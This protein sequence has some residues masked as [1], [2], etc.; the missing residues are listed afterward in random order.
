MGS[1]VGY[2][3]RDANTGFI[4]AILLDRSSVQQQ[5]KT[6]VFMQS[7]GLPRPSMGIVLAIIHDRGFVQRQCKIPG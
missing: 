1:V 4:N 7:A 6:P 2:S 3:V 5:R